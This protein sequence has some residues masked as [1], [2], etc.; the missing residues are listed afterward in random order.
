MSGHDM[1]RNHPDDVTVRGLFTLDAVEGA[2]PQLLADGGK[3]YQLVFG[4]GWHLESVG[5]VDLKQQVVVR[6]G[7]TV[8][9][10]G[11]AAQMASVQQVGP[12]LLV[13][14]IRVVAH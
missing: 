7:D 12:L 13:L 5:I 6:P 11:R 1:T 10:R 2:A 3:T 8:I 14:D 9:V 4:G